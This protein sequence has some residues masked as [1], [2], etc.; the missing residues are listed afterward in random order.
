MTSDFGGVLHLVVYISIFPAWRWS[1]H[2]SCVDISMF[3]VI[4][5][6]PRFDSVVSLL[7]KFSGCSIANLPY[8]KPLTCIQVLPFSALE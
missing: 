3:V 2:L 4:P 7:N 5:Y 1:G 6:P 8:R